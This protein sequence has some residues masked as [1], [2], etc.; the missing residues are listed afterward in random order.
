MAK[1][2]DVIYQDLLE[3][4]WKMTEIDNTEIFELLRILQDKNNKQ[5]KTKK[6]KVN[7]SLIG[8]ITGKD[9]RQSS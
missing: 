6:V 4:G 5:S 1:N 2:I 9:P 3:A 7:E 8:A